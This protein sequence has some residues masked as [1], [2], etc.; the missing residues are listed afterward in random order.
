[1][2]F[3]VVIVVLVVFV[4][5]SEFVFSHFVRKGIFVLN[6]IF[7][8]TAFCSFL[9]PG[10]ALVPRLPRVIDILPFQDK[11]PFNPMSKGFPPFWGNGKG[12]S[13]KKRLTV[14]R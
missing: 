12:A 5:S 8:R 6:F 9:F 10:V 11:T 13:K 3:F 14:F 2:V 7:S 4:F 1:M